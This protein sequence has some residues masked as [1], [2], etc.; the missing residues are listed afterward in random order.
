MAQVEEARLRRHLENICFLRSQVLNPG[1][2]KRTAHYIEQ[3]LRSYGLEIDA[4][5]FYHWFTT[6]HRN[7]NIIGGFPHESQKAPCLIIGAH[8]DA[9]PFSPGADDNGSGVA[10]LLEAARI[11]SQT[12]HPS[13]LHVRFVAF[14]MEEYGMIGSQHYVE[15]LQKNKTAVAGMLSLECVGYTNSQPGSQ[16]IPPGLPIQVPDRGDFIGIVGNADSGE[17]KECLESAVHQYAPGLK[18][19][20]LL[21]PENGRVLPATRL[22][23]H[24]PFWDAGYP[25]L[26]VTDTAFLRNPHYHRPS[27]R[28]ETLD[29]SFMTLLTQSIVAFV[30]ELYQTR[31]N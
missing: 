4:D 30:K 24:S 6:W 31:P 10:V 15:T 29:F 21:V 13:R 2:V 23:D 7:K 11:L 5:G 26:L 19:V 16:I 3:E 12:N 20:G 18:A 27:D 22:S 9:V 1:A 25:A 8:Y 14:A 28:I 17:L